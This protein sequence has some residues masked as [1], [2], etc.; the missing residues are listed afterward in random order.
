MRDT[1][2]LTDITEV[3]VNVTDVN[4]PPVIHNLPDTLNIQEDEQGVMSLFNVT[5]TDQ[6]VGDVITYSITTWPGGAPFDI[7]GDGR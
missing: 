1:G 4:E 7:A 2:G 3:T 5:A 6:D